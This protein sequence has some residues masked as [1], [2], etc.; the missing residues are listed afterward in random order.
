VVYE[1]TD[2][3]SP[4]S[5][6]ENYRQIC[7]SSNPVRIRCMVSFDWFVSHFDDKGDEDMNNDTWT[8]NFAKNGEQTTIYC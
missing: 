6:R 8:Y 4:H 7:K 2:R 3:L 5:P 1:D